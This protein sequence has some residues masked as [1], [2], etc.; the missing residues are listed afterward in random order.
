[1]CVVDIDCVAVPQRIYASSARSHV[2]VDLES[3][4]TSGRD[5]TQRH[6]V[7]RAHMPC[8]LWTDCE[9]CT[10]AQPLMIT[11]LLYI[12]LGPAVSCI[13]CNLSL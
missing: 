9:A 11:M 10:A 13:T 2:D 6:C 5:L 8:N 7:S 1:M 4:L 3:Q 12:A